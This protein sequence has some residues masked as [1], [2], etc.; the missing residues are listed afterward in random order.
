MRKLDETTL[1]ILPWKEGKPKRIIFK[2]INR[3]KNFLLEGL[4]GGIKENGFW[5][6]GINFLAKKAQKEWKLI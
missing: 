5:E 6:M 3:N 2:I 1:S 4:I